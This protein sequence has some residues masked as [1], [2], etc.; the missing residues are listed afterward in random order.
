MHLLP[1]TVFRSKAYRHAQSERGDIL[2]CANLGE[3]AR[4][5]G[6]SGRAETYYREALTRFEEV[7]GKRDVA[8]VL[9]NL[10]RMAR[11]RG[12][13]ALARALLD[14]SLSRFRR[15][16]FHRG[17][18]ECVAGLAGLA[19]DHNEPERAAMLLGWVEARFHAIET[20]M[21]PADRADY[22]CDV[23]A[24][25][26]QLS[27]ADFAEARA[28]GSAM[29]YDEMLDDVQPRSGADGG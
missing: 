28:R 18:A 1:G 9:H 29:S 21:W 3:V 13:D 4:V 20:P 6:D 24:S 19:V 26:G 2:P 27:T 11:Q 7:G 15:M 17:I 25:R 10:G 12:D 23:A 22:D 14:E 5:Q 8:R 16:E